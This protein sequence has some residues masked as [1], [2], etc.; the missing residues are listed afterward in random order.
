MKF[1][2]RNKI[3]GD[4]HLKIKATNSSVIFTL[5]QTHTVHKSSLYFY[6]SEM[7]NLT[8]SRYIRIRGLSRLLH[9]GDKL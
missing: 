4:R 3:R 9:Y 5:P 8:T 7:I 6:K 2:K 1:I